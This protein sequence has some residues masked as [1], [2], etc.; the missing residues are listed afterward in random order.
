[1][2]LDM[3]LLRANSSQHGQCDDLARSNMELNARVRDAWGQDSPRETPIF[4]TQMSGPSSP[5]TK[6][7]FKKPANLGAP[8]TSHSQ[9][10][11]QRS[12]QTSSCSHFTAELKTER[13][14]P[15]HSER[16]PK[17][18]SGG[19]NKITQLNT[20]SREDGTSPERMFVR[21]T[22]TA[23]V[24]RRCCHVDASASH[25]PPRSV[26][27]VGGIYSGADQT[28]AEANT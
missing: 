25:S 19:I 24:P 4:K 12:R 13:S 9:I 18:A 11:P 16:P 15:K 6:T 20:L 10:H 5:P 2:T 27:T 28:K 3:I 22:A 17:V 8:S 21:R 26:W 23:P 7:S 14:P 1:M